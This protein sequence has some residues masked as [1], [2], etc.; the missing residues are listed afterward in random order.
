MKTFDEII[1]EDKVNEG[2]LYDKWKMMD[3]VDPRRIPDMLLDIMKKLDDMENID[4][5]KSLRK[6]LGL[7]QKNG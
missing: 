5:Y 6:K 3:P 2:S 4:T 1:N 7:P